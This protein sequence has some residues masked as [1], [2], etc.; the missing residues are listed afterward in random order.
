M[1][2]EINRKYYSLAKYPNLEILMESQL[3]SAGANQAKLLE[4]YK[5]NKKSV[6]QQLFVLKIV[7]GFLFVF[8]PAITIIG[9]LSI[10]EDHPSAP[11]ETTLFIYSFVFSI[12]FIM[13][14]LYVLLMGLF[15]T[16]AFMSGNAFKWLQTL[17]FSKKELRKLG[18][19]TVFRN[20]DVAIITMII[21]FPIILLIMTQDF[22]LFLICLVSSV[23]NAVS[24]F[25]I[26]IILSQKMANIFSESKVN[27]KR[28][29]LLRIV[30]MGGFFILAFGTSFILTLLLNSI[31]TFFLM[32]PTND[33]ALLLNRILSFIPYPF[34]I[35][36]VMAFFTTPGTIPLDIIFTSMIGFALSIALAF[37]LYR[38][39]I[40][41]IKSA[42]KTEIEIEKPKKRKISIEEISI[43]I[44]TISTTKSFIRKDLIST[45][46]DYQSFIFMIMP[47]VYPVILILSMGYVITQEVSSIDSIIILW[48]II[49]A[50]N[51]FIPFMLVAGFL[52]MEES[53]S[54]I[55]S[56]L[57]LLSREQAR[58]KIYLTLTIQAIGLG[59]MGI[60][61]M[62]MTQSLLL[63]VLFLLTIPI[64]W[65]LL[66]YTFEVKISLFG[67][68]KYK[69]VIEEVHKG[70]KVL[71]WI[72]IVGSELLIYFTIII[73]EFNLLA[74]YGIM[75]MI[76]GLIVIAIVGLGSLYYV[77]TKM[78]PKENELA[79]YYTGGLLR[80]NVLAGAVV[81]MVLYFLFQNLVGFIELPILPFL[82]GLPP[83]DSYFYLRTI[84]VI[85]IFPVFILLFF[86]VVPKGMK[87]PN[88]KES[89]KQYSN[90][91]GFFKVRPLGMNI[92]ILLSSALLF[93]I[94][95][96]VFS[97]FGVLTINLG[98]L[99][100]YPIWVHFYW[101]LIPGIWEEVAFRGVILRLQLR[102]FSKLTSIILSG[103]FFGLMHFVNLLTIGDLF[104]VLNQVFY[105]TCLGISFAYIY[106]K[107][108]SLIPTI[109]LH[110][111]V[112]IIVQS[113][114]LNTT[115]FTVVSFYLT[116]GLG[117]IPMVLIL[118]VVAIIGLIKRKL[119]NHKL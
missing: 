27:S 5:K 101:M 11:T 98:V 21:G 50:V 69:Y 73:I 62:I 81:I 61:L 79:T 6:K 49:V 108:E 90:T 12:F 43:E 95:T 1:E 104:S 71:K 57:P 105:A 92:L 115:N 80:R 66:L 46:R 54:T 65:I 59:L 44:K 87:L 106:V 84:D 52:N 41:Q 55:L 118:A 64:A 111:F 70:R 110:Y 103:V 117:L 102:K 13:S 30:T 42:T 97:L 53:G 22:V 36:Y 91:I 88:G 72:V 99:L 67:K 31:D 10:S 86:V 4:K 25:S 119:M 109:T 56:S 63:L 89:L 74:I 23:I 94:P 82:F 38:V 3:N 93:L 58:A 9:F 15:S 33:S 68:M 20:M 45:T 47:I 76:I 18:Y 26:L 60:V 75:G 17:P 96:I 107:T 85:L 83:E 100:R 39:A 51:Q 113:F 37:L 32:F 14:I 114:I 7:Y 8:L 34:G 2:E 16:S 40:K 19:V 116:F 28:T 78:F 24:A 77:F 35:S 29:Y 48:S 112:N